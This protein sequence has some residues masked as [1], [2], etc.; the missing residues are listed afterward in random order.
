MVVDPVCGM[1][2][3][4]KNSEIKSIVDGNEVYFC[5]PKCKAIFLKN[6]SKYNVA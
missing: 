1:T 6:R 4:E 2:V 5:C 3:D